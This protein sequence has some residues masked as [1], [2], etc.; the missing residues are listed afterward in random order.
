VEEVPESLQSSRQFKTLVLTDLCDSVALVERIGDNAAADLF[1]TLDAQVMQLLRRWNGRLIDRSDGMFLL[2]NAPVDGLGF[3][4][5]YLDVL[6][7]LG[8][9]KKL[10]LRARLGMHVG[11]V[12]SWHNSE[13]AVAAGAK[14][15][16]VEGLAKPMAARLMALA[17]PGQILLSAAAESMMRSAQ[18]E[19]DDRGARLKWKSHGHWH[20]K[21][22]PS[23]QEVFEV[24]REGRAPLRMPPGS[25]K[26]WRELPRWRRPLAL[27]TEA[28]LLL[29]LL[30]AAWVIVRP[31]PAIAFAERNWVLV[32][33]VRN[34]TGESL[35]DDSIEQAF[36]IS[37]EQSRFVNVL[38]ELQVQK[39]LGLMQL[40]ADQAMTA[41][42]A[43]E[44]A[45]RDGARAVLM[46][47][48][49]EIGNRF[50]FTVEIINPADGRTLDSLYAEGRG[51]NS[52][53]ASVDT[54]SGRLRTR[55]G[56]PSLALARDSEPLPE[57]TTSNLEALRAYALAL[58]AMAVRDYVLAENLYKKALEIDPDFALANMGLARIYWSGLDEAPALAQLDAALSHRDRLPPRDQMYL[59][60][61]QHELRSAAS[62][63]PQ[64]KLLATMYPDYFAGPSNTSWYLIVENRF[65]E[66]LPFAQAAAVPQDPMRAVP[67]DHVGRIQLALGKAEQALQT[68]REAESEGGGKPLRY[69]GNAL[70]VLGRLDEAQKL[71]EQIRPAPGNPSS[72]YASMDRISVALSRSQRA[73]AV[74][75]AE[76]ASQLSTQYGPDH[77]VQFKLL[78]QMT[79][80]LA[81]DAGSSAATLA[82]LRDESVNYARG[83]GNVRGRQNALFRALVAIHLAQRSGY[84]ASSRRGLDALPRL[85]E[86]DGPFNLAWMR[87]LVN[88]TQARLEGR[89]EESVRLLAPLLDGTEAVQVRV[90]L[91]AAFDAM[92][93]ARS[94]RIHRAWLSEN[95]GRA[96][97]EFNG[98]QLLQPLNVSD[99]LEAAEKLRGESASLPRDQAP[100][101]QLPTASLIRP[102]S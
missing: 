37:L 69:S 94:A 98:S 101:P 41:R 89:P 53:L 56:E 68:F 43:S 60:A 93:D 65:E 86:L 45:I 79:R 72:L 30:I 95:L 32:G 15:L 90:E 67:L 9:E 31:E 54:V 21:G 18:R 46:A 6:D 55:L 39:T 10:P 82:S 20:F 12:L 8:K 34:L 2:F 96:Y 66:A 57:V 26:A 49:D 13:E 80:M 97:V 28:V 102:A 5:D 99:V 50:R 36:R 7:R 40:D 42:V 52:L 87:R 14:S 77:V 83:T 81:S 11:Y 73:Q 3:A 24:G 1:R 92:G 16:E 63:L 64:W 25:E 48:V 61:W 27:V 78:E 84:T 22:M 71:L 62:P 88:A 38:S 23:A 47:R 91:A 44:V 70:A 75:E 100:A 33:G 59:E 29:G 51:V 19:L 76:Q 85:S 74:A 4:L 35:L 17:W 58:K